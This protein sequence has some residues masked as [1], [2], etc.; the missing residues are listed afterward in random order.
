MYLVIS[1]PESS[2]CL[3]VDLSNFLINVCDVSLYLVETFW[4]LVVSFVFAHELDVT[5]VDAFHL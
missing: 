3:F 5:V 1:A 2:I 4:I